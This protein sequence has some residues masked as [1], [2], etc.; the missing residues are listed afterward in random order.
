[1]TLKHQNE[2]IKLSFK[3]DVG[4]KSQIIAGTVTNNFTPDPFFEGPSKEYDFMAFFKDDILNENAWNSP[5]RR[6]MR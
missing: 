6:S 2:A 5:G 4:Q 3:N 1:M